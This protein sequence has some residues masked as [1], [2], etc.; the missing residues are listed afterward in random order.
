MYYPH[1]FFVVF[2]E[3]AVAVDLRIVLVGCL[4]VLP[5]FFQEAE[6]AVKIKGLDD[7]DNV[8]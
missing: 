6:H 4:I 7:L 5:C 2:L 1:E 3:E 8:G